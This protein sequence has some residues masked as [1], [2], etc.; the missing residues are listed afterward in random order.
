MYRSRYSRPIPVTLIKSEILQV[1]EVVVSTLRTLGFRCALVGGAACGAFGISRVATDIDVVVLTT[2]IGQEEIKRSL[3]VKD[4]GFTLVASKNPYATYKVLWYE[5][6]PSSSS[7]YAPRRSCK[8]DIL[9]PG[10]MNIPNVP[11]G[12]TVATT[13]GEWKGLPL[14]PFIPLLMLKLQAWMDHRQADK[15]YLRDKQHT[16]VRDI[17][18]LLDIGVAGISAGAFVQYD[19]QQQFSTSEPAFPSNATRINMHRGLAT[20]SSP[21]RLPLTRSEVAQV[22]KL[23]MDAINA[24][25]FE[26]MLMGETACSAHGGSRVSAGIDVVVLA[27]SVDREALKRNLAAEDAR[28]VLESP[29]DPNAT[30]KVLLYEMPSTSPSTYLCRPCKISI[31]MPQIRNVPDVPVERIAYGGPGEWQGLPLMPVVPLL[32]LRLQDWT[33]HLHAKTPDLRDKRHTDARDIGELLE[34]A[35]RQAYGLDEDRAWMPAS[36]IEG[37]ERLIPGYIVIHPFTAYKWRRIGF[38]WA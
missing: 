18:E 29:R 30:H 17:G 15:Q 32:I 28:F 35:V 9:V 6:P 12:H 37:A 16:D 10:I 2:E 38:S 24:L 26:C 3:A 7:P 21:Q 20:F 33:D 5:I 22:T 34:I 11:R 8:V 25:G 31:A 1:A 14:M 13:S 27:T 36:F 19:L 23:V 4:P